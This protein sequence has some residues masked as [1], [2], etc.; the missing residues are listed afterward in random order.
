MKRKLHVKSTAKRWIISKYMPLSSA[1]K[2]TQCALKSPFKFSTDYVQTYSARR[3]EAIWK[4]CQNSK[5]FLF[6]QTKYYEETFTFNTALQKIM[7]EWKPMLAKTS[8]FV[9]IF[10]KFFSI[11]DFLICKVLW[12]FSCL[13]WQ[14]LLARW[15]ASEYDNMTSCF[16]VNTNK[17]R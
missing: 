14:P 12:W 6:P 7:P 11:C 1:R 3:Q 5:Y 4:T 8:W 13:S 10:Q 16:M 2:M 17:F 9:G 15:S